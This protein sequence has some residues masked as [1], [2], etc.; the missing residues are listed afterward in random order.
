MRKSKIN[1]SDDKNNKLYSW[2]YRLLRS[3]AHPISKYW[4]PSRRI[5]NPVSSGSRSLRTLFL[6]LEGSTIVVKLG[7]YLPVFTSSHSRRIESSPTPLCEPEISQVVVAIIIIISFISCCFISLLPP[8]E[9][10]DPTNVDYMLFLHGSTVPS[11]PGPGHCWGFDV[12]LRHPIF[13]RTP[14]NEWSAR[15]RYLYLSHNRQKTIMLRRDSNPQSQQANGRSPI[16]HTARPV[17][18]AVHMH[19]DKCRDTIA[20]FPPYLQWKAVYIAFEPSCLVVAM[21]PR[22]LTSYGRCWKETSLFGVTCFESVYID[23]TSSLASRQWT[24]WLPYF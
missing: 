12:T 18:S 15:R 5:V 21:V 19:G 14:L 22:C 13:G 20:G 16:P 9:H 23:Y 4:P 24:L 3:Y 10:V 11:G 2:R 7:K 6:K 1:D 17:G 8:P